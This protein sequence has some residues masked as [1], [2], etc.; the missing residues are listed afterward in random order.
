MHIQTFQVL[1]DQYK[2]RFVSVFIL[3]F[4]LDPQRLRLDIGTHLIFIIF[5]LVEV[6]LLEICA[7]PR[8]HLS[9]GLKDVRNVM[10][11]ELRI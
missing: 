4:N 1:E 7:L 9:V 3:T 11:N 5:F 6:T 10:I 2:S 8:S